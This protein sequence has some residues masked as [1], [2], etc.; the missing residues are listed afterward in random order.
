MEELYDERDVHAFVETMNSVCEQCELL[1]FLSEQAP[2]DGK[3]FLLA[4][5]KMTSTN[6]ARIRLA[7]MSRL[8]R[9]LSPVDLG[10]G[11]RQRRSRSPVKTP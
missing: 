11:G 1:E 9:S 3:R 10:S 6:N 4:V 8:M 7:K 5:D 2:E